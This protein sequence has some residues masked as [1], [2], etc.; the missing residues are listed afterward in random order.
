[1]ANE[2]LKAPPAYRDFVEHFPALGQAWDL[3]RKA[4]AAGPLQG[5]TRRLLKLAI[6]VGREA[7]GATHSGVRKA[8]EA[9]AT[10]EEIEQVVALSASTLGL[11]AAVKIHRWVREVLG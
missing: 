10:R 11:P 8:L 7:E 4:E 9:G 2:P 3:I 6:A 1:M 5:K